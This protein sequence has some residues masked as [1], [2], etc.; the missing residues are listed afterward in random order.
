MTGSI[1]G[2]GISASDYLALAQWVARIEA[3][4]VVLRAREA[5]FGA[6]CAKYLQQCAALTPQ[7]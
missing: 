4:P 3:W 5:I 7:Q 1:G 6:D 2:I